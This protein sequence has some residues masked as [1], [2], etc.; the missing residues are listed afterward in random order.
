MKK[1]KENYIKICP[2]CGG[3]DINI[4]PTFYAA[5]ATGIPPR[6]SCKSCNHIILVFPEVKESEIEEFRKKLKEGK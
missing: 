5:F 6:F 2:K 1:K 3:T 4:D